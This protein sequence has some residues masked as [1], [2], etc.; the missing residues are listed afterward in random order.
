MKR[1]VPLTMQTVGVQNTYN[2]QEAVAKM[3]EIAKNPGRS[4][5]G[6]PCAL[7]AESS[8]YSKEMFGRFALCTKSPNIFTGKYLCAP[9]GR[10]GRPYGKTIVFTTPVH[11]CNTPQVLICLSVSILFHFLTMKHI[12]VF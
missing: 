12:S 4:R 5:R 1:S 9:G 6:G 3:R 7:P 10:K 11:F 8:S 2:Q